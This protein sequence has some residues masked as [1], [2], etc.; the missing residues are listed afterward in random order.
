MGDKVKQYAWRGLDLRTN[1]LYRKDGTSSNIRN[2][3]FDSSRR[4]RKRVDMD[5]VVIPRGIDAET[6][7]F[8]DKLPFQAEIISIF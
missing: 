3:T 1:I 2:M 4:L 6:G 7:E 8:L 5:T